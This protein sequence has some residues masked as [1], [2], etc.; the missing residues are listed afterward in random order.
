MCSGVQTGMVV[1]GCWVYTLPSDFFSLHK[2]VKIF[3]IKHIFYAY[4][5]SI[6]LTPHPFTPLDISAVYATGILCIAGSQCSDGHCPWHYIIR[7]NYYCEGPRVLP[8]LG[9]FRCIYIGE[10]N[11]TLKN[12]QPIITA[13]KTNRYYH[14]I[15]IYYN[16]TFYYV[17]VN[18]YRNLNLK[19]L[20]YIWYTTHINIIHLKNKWRRQR[21]RRSLSE[22][23]VPVEGK[24]IKN[25]NLLTIRF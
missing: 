11:K 8:A 10:K 16:I 24:N 23:R 6:Q 7:R 15:I 25:N 20:V 14:I 9:M 4:M 13:P 21:R 2:N 12:R 1:R 17:L 22:L 3:F 18:I 19:L 5:I